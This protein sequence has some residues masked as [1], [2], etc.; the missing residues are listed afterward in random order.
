M[1]AVAKSS[2]EEEF[3][4]DG[5]Q[6]EDN[7]EFVH[8]T[9][10]EEKCNIIFESNNF[11]RENRMKNMPPITFWEFFH[12]LAPGHFGWSVMSD[13]LGLRNTYALFGLSI[14]IVGFAAYLSHTAASILRDYPGG[15]SGVL[16]L[17]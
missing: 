5:I 3:K 16:P 11:N 10:Q 17:R 2:I 14:P 9:S 12:C 15:I 1:L 13:Y 6:R 8:Y 4:H 7:L